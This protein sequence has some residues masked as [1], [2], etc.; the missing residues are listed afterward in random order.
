MDVEEGISFALEGVVAT[1]LGGK[2][3]HKRTRRV[4]DMYTF[5]WTLPN[6]QE[7]S[8]FMEKPLVL[9]RP[10]GATSAQLLNRGD[11]EVSR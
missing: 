7:I 3:F 11:L 5:R 8:S 9:F 10:E 2:W 1:K 6:G 4:G